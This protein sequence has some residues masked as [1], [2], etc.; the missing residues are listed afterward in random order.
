MV[1]DTNREGLYEQIEEICQLLPNKSLGEVL[2]LA[3]DR[4]LFYLTDR[5]LMNTLKEFYLQNM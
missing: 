3:T 1:Y 2:S 4:E 5:E